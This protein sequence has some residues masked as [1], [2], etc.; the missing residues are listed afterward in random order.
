[1]NLLLESA[2]TQPEL[3]VEPALSR[4]ITLLEVFQKDPISTAILG[5][6]AMLYGPLLWHWYHGWLFHSINLE[7]EYFSHGVVGLPLAALLAW[8]R[9][10]RWQELPDVSHPVG[11]GLLGLASAFYLSRLADAINLSF[12]LLL[13]GLCLWFKGRPGL[14][15]QA[16][17]LILIALA[18][19]TDLPYLIVPYTLGLQKFIAASAGFL[20]LQLNMDVTVKTIYLF[21]GERI[22]EVA[23][24]CAGLKALFTNLYFC[25]IGLYWTGAWRSRL[26]ST[27]LMGGA[28]VISVIVNI[29]RNTILAILHGTGQDAA[30]HWLHES[31]GGELYWILIVLLLLGLFKVVNQLWSLPIPESDLEEEEI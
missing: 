8:E 2:M 13:V 20:L 6:L 27:V 24:H 16:F 19:P 29:I 5:L 30:F 31:W 15:L 9:R 26:K 4:R 12:P 7:H 23:P 28:V 10:D 14:R 17:P 18:T 25:L 11:A 1:V 3:P 21:V 22:V